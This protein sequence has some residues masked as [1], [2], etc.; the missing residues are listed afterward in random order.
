MGFGVSGVGCPPRRTPDAARANAGA[1]FSSSEWTEGAAGA[2]IDPPPPSGIASSFAATCQAFRFWISGSRLPGFGFPGFRFPGPGFRFSGPGFRFL[3]L[4]SFATRW[5][6]PSN[7]PPRLA[8]PLP[9]PRPARRVGYR[10][11]VSISGFQVSISGFGFRVSRSGFQVSRPGFRHLVPPPPAGNCLFFCGQTPTRGQKT[12]VSGFLVPGFGF[13]FRGPGLNFQF[14]GPGF[15]IS[16]FG[17]RAV[18]VSVL[19]AVTPAGLMLHF[20]VS[21][22]WPP[23]FGFPHPGFGFRA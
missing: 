1:C 13:G 18:C 6:S 15:Q 2:A 16:D 11:R 5:V 23:G 12:A 22:Y 20:P 4:K 17:C 14:L 21:S 10:F 3:V 19:T 7:A 8:L 9:L